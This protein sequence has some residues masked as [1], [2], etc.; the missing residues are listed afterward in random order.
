MARVG[1]PTK[2]TRDFLE[3]AE[4]VLND[5]I[6]AIIFTD[7]EL[8]ELINDKLVP[9]AQVSETRW[10]EWKAGNM[11]NPIVEE[12]RGLYKKALSQQKSNLFQ[13]M[14]KDDKAWTRFAWIIERKF[15]DWNLRKKIEE[16]SDRTIKIIKEDFTSNPESNDE[17]EE[18]IE[19]TF[20][21]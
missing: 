4:E 6:N 7:A 11:K 1:R 14:R 13:E 2:L 5:D 8:R 16:T 9:D 10:E 3:A 20:A 12:F 18:E 17:Q 21:G 15:D 19:D